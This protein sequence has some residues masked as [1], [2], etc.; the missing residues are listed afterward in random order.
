M[1]QELNVLKPDFQAVN[2]GLQYLLCNPE[3]SHPEQ[4]LLPAMHITKKNRHKY[5]Q[6]GNRYVMMISA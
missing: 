6:N 3:L 4:L 2:A 5:L 1:S